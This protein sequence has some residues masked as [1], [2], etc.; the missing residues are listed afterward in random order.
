[1]FSRWPS[2]VA[3]LRAAMRGAAGGID[4]L[5]ARHVAPGVSAKACALVYGDLDAAGALPHVRAKDQ[6]ALVDLDLAVRV[7][8]EAAI[9]TL[10]M[11]HP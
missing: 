6:D 5:V 8:L 9:F 4:A 3:R 11:S 10:V 7:E 1:M 2:W